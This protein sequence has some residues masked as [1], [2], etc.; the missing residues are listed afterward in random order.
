MNVRQEAD[1]EGNNH[2]HANL[3]LVLRAALLAAW[4]GCLLWLSLASKLPPVPTI[5]AWDKLQHAI[6]HAILTLLAGR[7][8]VSLW[9]SHRHGWWSGFGLSLLVGL[10]IEVAQGTFT[11]N[12]QAD[13][14]DLIANLVGAGC[15]LLVALVLTR[16]E[17]ATEL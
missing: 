7:F 4:I 12:R 10:V 13:W 9:R 2:E 1:P 14:H 6:A 11:R 5:L 17:R 3:T 16:K 15:V 8:F